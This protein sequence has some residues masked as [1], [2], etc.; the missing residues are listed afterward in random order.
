MSDPNDDP[1]WRSDEEASR[2]RDKA[3]ARLLKTPPKPEERLKRSGARAE[4][5]HSGPASPKS[6]GDSLR[7]EE[8]PDAPQRQP[9]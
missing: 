5:Q 8:P 6:K 3:L 7:T 1:E 9:T 4:R 2:L